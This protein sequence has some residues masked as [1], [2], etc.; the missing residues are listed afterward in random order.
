VVLAGEGSAVAAEVY[1]RVSIDYVRAKLPD[2]SY[3]AEEYSLRDDGRFDGPNHETSADRMSSQEVARLVAAPLK[4]Q[5]YL[6]AGDPQLARLLIV[7]CYGRSDLPESYSSS[8][9][10]LEYQ[11]ASGDPAGYA[12]LVLEERQLSREN[13]RR[14]QAEL[15]G[16][17]A[18]S[19][20]SDARI[21]SDPVHPAGNADLRAG[22][23]F[24]FVP[25]AVENRYFVIL[26][27]YDLRVRRRSGRFKLLWETRVSMKDSRDDFEAAFPAMVRLASWHLG[28][29]SHGLLAAQLP[30]GPAGLSQVTPPAA[31][32]RLGQ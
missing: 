1:S 27:A 29:D 13:Q 28:L 4:A 21:G 32:A 20:E 30:S 17:M 8:D 12:A 24:L 14:E 31:A 22:Q 26:R 16:F 10:F 9:G 25:E 3:R 11:D 6:L 5:N 23:R 19:C 18:P 15:A 7:V 2:G